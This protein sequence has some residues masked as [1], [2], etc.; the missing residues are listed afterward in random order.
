MR[1]GARVVTSLTLGM[2][3]VLWSGAAFAQALTAD[4]AVKIALDHSTA[5]VNAHA[6]VLAARAGV[7][8]AYSGVL[9]HFTATYTRFGSTTDNAS[10]SGLVRVG[11]E[12]VPGTFT[13]DVERHGTTPTVS[14]TWSIFD[15]SAISGVS[16][17]RSG[18]KAAELRRTSTRSN[19]AFTT[20]QQF[21]AVVQA[22]RLEQVSANAL[23]LARDDERR[24][25]ALFEVGSVSRSDV[26]QAQV[27]TAQSELDSLTAYEGVTVQR[28]AL[29][30]QLGLEESKLGEVDTVMTVEERTVDEATLF[31]E[32]EKNRPDLRA[33][34]LSLNSARSAVTSA[35]LGR[36]PFITVGGTLNSNLKSRTTETAAGFSPSASS[37]STD[38]VMSGQ[39]A[40]NWDVFDG[41]A[42]DSRVASARSQFV[43]AQETRDALRRGLQ[44]EVHQALLDYQQALAR[45]RVARRALDAAA[46]N[47]KLTQQK[48]N[49]GSA[50]TLE[51]INAQVQLQRAD[52]DQVA[53]LAAIRVAEAGL[54]RVRGR[55]E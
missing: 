32:A 43:R 55:S 5:S 30:N 42:I 37:S 11:S 22:I 12:L 16:S 34:E 48:Y 6:D 47:V 13:S 8:G 52:S 10:Q 20:R 29:A 38:R 49:V 17:A 27:R 39:I 9:P 7:Y 1:M 4:R 41:F 50:T 19:V 14:G 40:L 36:L 35:R 23:R 53:A 3:G 26:L 15:L 46:E 44:G 54:D 25:R 28:V 21:Y 31:A 18:L 33:A 2:V 51:L 45:E 24:V